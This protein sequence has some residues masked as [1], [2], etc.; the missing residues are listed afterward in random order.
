MAYIIIV[1]CGT[2]GAPNP[3]KVNILECG[4]HNNCTISMHPHDAQRAR[5]L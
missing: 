3:I 4:V 1:V 5:D 2:M